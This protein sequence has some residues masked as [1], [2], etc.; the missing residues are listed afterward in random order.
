M[1]KRTLEKAIQ[2]IIQEVWYGFNNIRIYDADGFVLYPCR[3]YDKY[4]L[5]MVLNNDMFILVYITGISLYQMS[6][7]SLVG[8]MKRDIENAIAFAIMLD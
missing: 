1:R 4:E 8:C 7:R 3:A 2:R 5:R 6:I